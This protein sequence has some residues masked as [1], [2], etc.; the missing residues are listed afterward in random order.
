MTLIRNRRGVACIGRRRAAAFASALTLLT[1][2]LNGTAGAAAQAAIGCGTVVT[3]STR[4]TSD[5][6]PCPGMGIIIAASNITVDLNGHTVTG[7][8]RARGSGLD[9]G[10]VVLRQVRKVNLTNGTV[11]GF[12]AGVVIDGGGDNTVTRIKAIDNVNYRVVTGR[13]ATRPDVNPDAAAPCDLG[14]GIAVVDSVGN[15]LSNNTVAGNGP[16]SGIALVGRSSLN[17]VSNNRVRDNDLLNRPP[18][19]DKTMCGGQP[20]ELGPTGRLVQ[21]VGV[22]VEGPG[23]QHNLVSSNQIARSALAGVMVTAFR[24]AFPQN[25]NGFNKI[26][27]NTITQTGLRTRPVQ[28][29]FDEYHSS[30]I[31][32]HNAG[33]TEV[34]LSYGNTI[35]GNTS[36]D[37]VGGGIEVVGPV[38]GSGEVGVGGNTIVGNV[39]NN[40]VLTGIILAEGTVKTT[41]SGNKAHGNGRDKALIAQ[42][43]AQQPFVVWVGVDGADNN[44]GCASNVWSANL[45][46]TVNQSCVRANGGMGKVIGPGAP[47]AGQAARLSTPL[48]AQ[49]AHPLLQR[50]GPQG[51]GG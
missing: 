17:V 19:G 13:N 16:F 47:A 25:N 18:G 36:S 7:N 44:P 8:P 4:L 22:R 46:G 12:D 2:G 45:F 31:F 43:N 37:N 24:N 34:T 29:F 40:N 39:V 48:G 6:G 33:T 11:R 26:L 42:L 5:V 27:N 23:A 10:G 3:E 9:Q 50:G 49:R 14:D 32:L 30:G 20:G 21:G 28:N 1:A 38:P 41:V 35:A 51:A 15:A